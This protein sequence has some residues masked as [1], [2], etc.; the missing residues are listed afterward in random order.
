MVNNAENI[1]KIDLNSWNLV[2]KKV[3]AP[4]REPLLPLHTK[5]RVAA[6]T[7]K[8]TSPSVVPSP[9]SPL[10]SSPASNPTFIV[11]FSLNTISNRR[12][13][14]AEDDVEEEEQ[15]AT[16]KKKKKKQVDSDDE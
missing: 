2:F 16:Q 7:P 12:A 4:S 9:S 11:S 3:E 5:P 8:L 15:N 1:S 10:L 13:A 6:I 14:K